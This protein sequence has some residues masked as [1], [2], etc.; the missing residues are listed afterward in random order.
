[1]LKKVGLKPEHSMRYPHAFSGGQRQRIGIA[2]ALILNP[3]LVVADE[4]VSALDVSVQAQ[5]INLLKDLQEELGLT[6]IFIAHNLGVVRHLCNRVAVM[7]AGRVIELSPTE[8]LFND[9]KHQ[10]TCA[11]LAA[12][13]EAD[14]DLPM[15]FGLPGEVADVGNLPKG[16]AFAARCPESSAACLVTAPDFKEVSAGRSVACHLR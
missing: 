3:D 6:L 2:R 16:C 1:M 11:L 5:V 7:Y 15:R 9:P 4:A 12:V 10:Y 13:P 8:A 14:P